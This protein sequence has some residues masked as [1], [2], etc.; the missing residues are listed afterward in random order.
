MTYICPLCSDEFNDT[1]LWWAHIHLKHKPRLKESVDCP[2]INCF[3]SFN[4]LYSL[5]KHLSLVHI[6]SE[7]SEKVSDNAPTNNL[8]I[9]SPSNNLDP[10]ELFTCN[11]IS[12][13]NS[14]DELLT[15]E[16]D[17]IVNT[18]N[19]PRQEKNIVS[20]KKPKVEFT[21]KDLGNINKRVEKSALSFITKLYANPKV[22]RALIQEI[23]GNLM[24]FN[25]SMLEIVKEIIN[26]I[27]TGDDV[28]INDSLEDILNTLSNP[29]NDFR[30]EYMRQQQLKRE[31]FFKKPSTYFIDTYTDKR[32]NKRKV[33]LDIAKATGQM[34]SMKHTLKKFLELP[35]VF[36]KI[37]TYKERE[38][39]RTDNCVS[40][41]VRSEHWKKI[42][43]RFKGEIVWPL[44]KFIDD[45]ELNAPLGPHTLINKIG[46][47]YYQIG[48]MPP[49]YASKLENIFVSQIHNSLDRKTFGHDDVF[50][51]LLVD[52]K[53]LEEKGIVINTKN[54][55]KRIYFVLALIL[56]D[57]LGLNE[58]LGFTTSFNS[59]NYC[60]FC[61]SPMSEMRKLI[62]E[63]P[64]YLRTKLSYFLH[65]KNKEY[66]VDQDSVFN[67]LTYFHTMDN[68][69]CD[70]MH[71]FFD[72]LLR[73]LMPR[74]IKMLID[75]KNVDLDLET[76]NNR[77]RF[78][79]FGCCGSNT[80]PPFTQK[81]SN[82]GY[83]VCTASEMKALVKMFGFIVGDLVPKGHPAWKLWIFIRE[84][85]CILTKIN[86]TPDDIEKLKKLIKSHHSLY[87]QLCDHLR[88]KF[89]LL[90]H[91]IRILIKVGPL[92]P[93]SCMRFEGK[94]KQFTD[95]AK[96]I[97]SR[98]NICYSLALK[99]QLMFSERLAANR[100]FE[101][102]IECG[103]AYD[104]TLQS[105]DD[106]N[107]FSPFISQL[108]FDEKYSSMSWVK[109]HG[110]KYTIDV[111]LNISREETAQTNFVQ[112]KYILMNSLNEV[113][114]I[115]KQLKTVQFVA[116]Y[117]AF[118]VV[119]TEKWGIFSQTDLV[120]YK[121]KDVRLMHNK[122]T[123][124]S[125]I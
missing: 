70:I 40:S 64:K 43:S 71:D 101:T 19:L 78:F 30:T 49:E 41:Y 83:Y 39:A 48:C 7:V 113:F 12:R 68:L 85:L 115:F 38:Q 1:L 53:F 26:E 3:R 114:F 82:E 36:D 105:L 52:L 95:H 27:R 106:V 103:P 59:T 87:L 45:V 73:Y 2:Q 66:G 46:A 120:D 34:I 100:G 116:H 35:N 123:Y 16:S 94:H 118:R 80:P 110:T 5:K 88:P 50:R 51:P 117:H 107:K 58:C 25:A 99:N 29:F 89:H 81:N 67:K 9:P 32:T 31:G 84:I 54:G 98:R 60:R 11:E 93:L 63:S 61:I 24:S 109:V 22:S 20:V 57:N 17:Q 37:M 119:D 75:D 55:K 42:E 74:I 69:Y 76:L 4:N 65:A 102:D 62:Q 18:D 28:D 104:T 33:E 44:F 47:V 77:I 10:F 56:G 86:L 15:T 92:L 13:N 14:S 91:Y 121:P 125:C 97:T 6:Q 79:G 96:V 21:D 124:I 23:V 108:L 90:I 122:S 111:A 112:I 8:D 72:G